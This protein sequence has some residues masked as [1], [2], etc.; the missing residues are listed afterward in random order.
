LRIEGLAQIQ[1]I[2]HRIKK[3]RGRHIAFRRVQGRGELNI[4]ATD[5]PG[6]LQPLL[7]GQIRISVSPVTGSQ[8]L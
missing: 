3:C 4:W 7:D 2:G 8:F 6:K 5:P 1:G